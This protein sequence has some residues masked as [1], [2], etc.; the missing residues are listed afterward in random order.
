MKELFAIYQHIAAARKI[1]EDIARTELEPITKSTN[2]QAAVQIASLIALKADLKQDLKTLADCKPQC[3][4][5]SCRAV[6][7]RM[8]DDILE[9]L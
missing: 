5:R 1:K 4:C 2:R 6:I 3:D 8:F 7:E 9:L